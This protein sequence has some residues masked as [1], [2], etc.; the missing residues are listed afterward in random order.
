MFPFRASPVE[1]SRQEAGSSAK[2]VR[3]QRI[4]AL[5]GRPAT[6]VTVDSL[7]RF[8]RKKA[9]AK[10][11]V[12]NSQS[13]A[14]IGPRKSLPGRTE[15]LDDSLFERRSGVFA[16]RQIYLDELD[17]GLQKCG[18]E[19]ESGNRR[20]DVRSGYWFMLVHR[21]VVFYS[22]TDDE[23][24]IQRVLHERMDPTLHLLDEG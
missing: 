14:Q 3:L 13:R 12:V 20:E 6:F 17:A 4:L 24:L 23:I 8:E 9:V 16:A 2:G 21:H 22:F 7:L 10:S 5:D 11:L 1:S 15:S 19:P 18:A